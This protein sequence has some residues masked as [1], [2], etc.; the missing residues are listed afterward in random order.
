MVAR[1]AVTVCVVLAE[2][3]STLAQEKPPCE[4]SWTFPVPFFQSLT[5]SPDGRKL[6]ISAVM[7]SWD[8]GYHVYAIG[9]D[10]TGFTKL[11]TSDHGDIYPV[12]SPDGSKIVFASTR[13]GNSEIYLMNA[14]GSETMRLTENEAKDTYPWWSPDGSRIVF[15][16]DRDGNYEVYVMDSNGSSPI[17]L[18]DHPANDYNPAWSPDGTRIVYESDR[19]SDGADELYL[20]GPDGTRHSSLAAEGVF[21]TWSPDGK[22]LLFEADEGLQMMEVKALGPMKLVENAVYGVWSPDGSKIALASFE[23][24]EECKDH[25][26][27]VIMNAD[28]TERIQLLPRAASLSPRW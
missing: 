20:I 25:H 27:V 19:N 17:R 1:I 22:K 15:T 16:S 24:D 5:W 12:W 8:D 26:S 2:A 14:D 21:P 23:F 18:T 11:S 7:T 28:G 13:D 10:G 3:V 6:A 9:A 4:K